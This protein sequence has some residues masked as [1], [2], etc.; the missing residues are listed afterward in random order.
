[1]MTVFI[2]IIWNHKTNELN[3]FKIILIHNS[4]KNCVR[5]PTVNK[6]SIVGATV[7]AGRQEADIDLLANIAAMSHFRFCVKK[8]QCQKNVVR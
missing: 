5:T 7:T 2:N 4:F 6:P 3:H 1:M 8:I